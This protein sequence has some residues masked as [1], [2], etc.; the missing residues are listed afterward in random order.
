MTDEHRW[1]L[2]LARDEFLHAVTLKAQTDSR[3]LAV[4]LE[5]SLGRGNADRYSDVDLHVL[6]RPDAAPAPDWEAWLGEL[7]PL[8][9]FNLLFGGAMVNAMTV[10]A[11]RIDLWPHTADTIQ[12]DPQ[13]VRVL[14]AHPG[15]V[16]LDGTAPAFA[17]EAA[18][19][20]A[21][22]V[23]REFWRCISLT[24]AVI[25]RGELLVAVQGL[26]VELGLVT[27][28]LM[29]EAG[30]VRDRGVK[31]LNAYLPAEAREAL[32]RAVLPPSMTPLHLAQAHL[33]LTEIV[34]LH[35]RRAAQHLRFTYP[36]ELEGTV[37]QYVSDE[38]NRLNLRAE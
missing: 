15:S 4:W 16:S 33:H 10:E 11:L 13:R 6:L 31:N 29:L 27:E 12:L 9:L 19:E 28:L 26:S 35:G 30:A 3:I 20:R 8:V 22:A 24:P 17:P 38:L 1:G 21:L 32:E 7:R 2:E 34:E 14:H 5:G 25:G 18:R 36:A 23:I 37:M